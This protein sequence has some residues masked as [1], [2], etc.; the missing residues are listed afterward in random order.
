MKPNFV[1]D[2][3]RLFNCDCMDF[4]AEIPGS[5]QRLHGRCYCSYI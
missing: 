2:N 1:L 3:V 5:W 4:M